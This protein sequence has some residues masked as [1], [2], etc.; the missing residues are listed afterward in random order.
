MGQEVFDPKIMSSAHIN[1]LFGSGV[2]GSAFPTMDGFTETKKII[3]EKTGKDV[4]IEEG[5]DLLGNDAGR[6]EVIALFENEFSKFENS[7]DF[8]NASIKNI[9]K[10]F[11]AVNSLVEVSENRQPQMKQVNIFT[12]NYDNI[13]ESSLKNC[14]LICTAVSPA[15]LA[16][17]NVFL[18]LVGYRPDIKKYIPTYLLLKLHGDSKDKSMV[19]PGNGKF[20]AALDAREFELLF[21]MKSKL[22]AFN[23]IL[24]VIGYSGHDEDV[25]GIIK[26][27][28]SSGLTVFWFKY[29]KEDVIPASLASG[30]IPVENESNPIDG[31]LQCQKLLSQLWTQS[32]GK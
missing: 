2:N 11:K 3:K 23:S 20:R 17:E 16:F 18:N 19:F 30:V 29:K 7:T 15:S 6:K 25:N 31:T 32:S 13:V 5:I 14:G 10:L 1:F 22:S 28:I 9:E 26:S 21:D 12:L 27:F 24:I 4:G 8:S